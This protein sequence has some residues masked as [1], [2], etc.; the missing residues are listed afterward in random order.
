MHVCRREPSFVLIHVGH[1][2]QKGCEL[3]VHGRGGR[4][5]DGSRVGL[6]GLLLLFLVLLPQEA[7]GR[8]VDRPRHVV[9]APIEGKFADL[10]SFLALPCLGWFLLPRLILLLFPLVVRVLLVLLL[11]VILVVALLPPFAISRGE[12]DAFGTSL[13]AVGLPA[14]P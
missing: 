9:L 14:L 13:H 5:S 1:G 2:G 12:H 11:R 3:G 4:G 10:L 7:I 8:L 6:D